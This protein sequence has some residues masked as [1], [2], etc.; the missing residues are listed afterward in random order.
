LKE[1]PGSI[2][3]TEILLTVPIILLLAAS[4]QWATLITFS[5]SWVGDS[6]A[7]L[8]IERCNIGTA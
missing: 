5:F 1:S 2:L 8:S 3:S 6:L 4:H 7:V